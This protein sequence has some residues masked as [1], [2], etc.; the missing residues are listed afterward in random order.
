MIGREGLGVDDDD[1]RVLAAQKVSLSMKLRVHGS[2]LS[3]KIISF[4]GIAQGIIVH[5]DTW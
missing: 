4:N 5:T 2:T 3:Y 1:R